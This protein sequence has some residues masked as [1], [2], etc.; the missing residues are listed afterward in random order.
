MPSFAN[1]LLVSAGA[2]ALLGTALFFSACQQDATPFGAQ[3]AA[4]RP[5]APKD[6]PSGDS[7][8][9]RANAMARVWPMYGGTVQRNMV[10]KTE[11]NIPAEWDVKKKTNVKWVAGLGSQAYG[12]PVVAGG[13]VFL[14][15]NNDGMKNPR[16]TTKPSAAGGKSQP[17][18][19]GVIMCF[20]ESDGKFLWQAIHDKLEA[21]R[22]NDWPL[23][24]I[25]SSPF[26]EGNRLYYV[27]NR[28]E[29]VCADTEGFADG[30]Q[31]VQDEKYKDPTDADI[32]WRLDMIG[33]LGV[34]PHNLAVCSPIVVGDLVFVVTGN[35]HDESHENIPAPNAPSFVAVDKKTGKVA[36]KDSSPGEKILHGQWSNPCYAEINGQAQVIF[37][38]GDGWLR[39]FDPK[40][41][42][43][44]WKFDCNPKSAK[45]VLGGRG[46]R[47]EI[48]ATPIVADNL[49][50]IGVGQDPEHGEGVGHLWCIDPSKAK[51]EN[52]DLSPV[53]DNFNPQD[54]VNK[55]SGLVWHHGGLDS[56]G[57]MIFRRTMSSCAVVDGLCYTANLSGFLECLDSKTGKPYWQHDMVSAI[58]GSPY[59]VDGKI[60]IGTDEGDVWVYQHGKEKKLLGKHEMD[61]P[62]LSTP[63]AVNGTLYVMT[64]SNLFAIGS[65]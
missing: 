35:G 24:G 12:N 55:N 61:G 42:K 14:G 65:K 64:R 45:Y 4:S 48:I 40:T 32:I 62:V 41:G 1:R 30:N 37:P 59:Y 6:K 56:K 19:K 8:T 21:G 22:V 20:R 34:F 57:E 18:D 60:Y 3:G 53:K 13:K 39:A 29:L 58:W 5:D 15:T 49:V 54:P 33:E 28:C 63:I 9:M 11:R 25:C 16:D 50:Y 47:N 43:I 38:G 46:T 51:G 26:V 7:A 52:V 2:V 27:S 17:L 23:Q 10:N 44:L 31:G 36:W